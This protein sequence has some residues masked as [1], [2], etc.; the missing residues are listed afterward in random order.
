[1]GVSLYIIYMHLFI[2]TE[3]ADA[4]S[5]TK[6]ARKLKVFKEYYKVEMSPPNAN[7]MQKLQL[8]LALVR[9]FVAAGC[10]KHLTVKQAWLL[11]L[12]GLE[13]SLW[14]FLGETVGKWSLVGYKV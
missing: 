4:A 2:I 13:I 12:V 14:F 3:R 11:F 8:D 7:E 5:K 9:E 6:V 10:W 1:M